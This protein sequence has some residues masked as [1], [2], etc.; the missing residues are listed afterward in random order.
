MIDILVSFFLS[1]VNTDH[2]PNPSLSSPEVVTLVFRDVGFIITVPPGLCIIYHFVIDSNVIIF[3]R[4]PNLLI[5]LLIFLSLSYVPNVYLFHID[6]MNRLR[7]E[8]LNDTSIPWCVRDLLIQVHL[9]FEEK[10]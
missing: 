5:M 4:F 10:T 9:H 7:D 1:I 8:A 2:R 3:F 6:K